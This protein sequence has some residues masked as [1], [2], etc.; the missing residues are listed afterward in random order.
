M[1]TSANRYHIPRVNRSWT[2]CPSQ[3]ISGGSC[4]IE[5]VSRHPGLQYHVEIE[6]SLRSV[7]WVPLEPGGFQSIINYRVVAFL[8]IPRIPLA[9]TDVT[10]PV[11]IYASRLPASLSLR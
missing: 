5:F 8:P 7:G 9:A 2:A 4:L 1:S 10:I 11:T 6:I 3:I